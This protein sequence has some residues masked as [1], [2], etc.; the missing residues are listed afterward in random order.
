MSVVQDGRVGSA[1]RWR[2]AVGVVAALNAVGSLG[3]AV[4]L[5]TGWLTLGDLTD[6][7]P[8]GST[9]LGGTAL[10]VLVFLPQSVLTV[11]AFRRS[12]ATA[13]AS[14][15]VGSML[16][17]WILLEVVFLQVF[18][19]LQ[20]VYLLIGLVQVGLGFLL[21]RHDPGL[22]P[23]ALVATIWSVVAGPTR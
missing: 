14:V 2:G 6:E 21:G 16:V 4:G 3:G 1:A 12:S 11:L 17:G 8:F 22:D 5:M 13:A 7:L 9:L 15:V 10:A 20:V 19:G 23:R 18:E